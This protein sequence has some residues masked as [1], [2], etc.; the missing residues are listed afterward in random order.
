MAYGTK[1]SF[2][3]IREVAFG[4][5]T[6][7]YVALGTPLGRH[8]RIISFNNSTDQAIYVSLNGTT[9]HIKVASN[10]F[11]LFDFSTNKIRDDGL[12]VA[13]ETQFYVKYAAALTRGAFWIEV[14]TGVGAPA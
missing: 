3:A 13:E 2:D 5:I 8:A 10:S 4:S 11:Q 12:F 6:A 7:S 1:V 9:D 14:I